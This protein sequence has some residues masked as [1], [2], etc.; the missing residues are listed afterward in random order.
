MSKPVSIAEAGRALRAGTT[1][2]VALTEAALARI[3]LK[4]P[5]LDAFVLL[6]PERALED[7]KRADAELAAGTDRGPFHGIPHALK[8]I[9]ATA[10][11]R[12]SCHS[13]LRL[14]VVPE[15]DCAVAEKFAEGGAVLLGK[16]ATHEFAIG[17][18]SFDLP[19]PPARNP[20]NRAHI[21]AGSSSG[22]GAAVA[23]GMMRMAMGSDTGGSIRGP[24]AYCGIVG[25]KPTYGRVSRRGVFPLSFTL[26]H[27]GPLS[28]N[29]EDAA[30]ALQVIAGFD[31]LDAACADMKVPDFREGMDKG[32]AGLRIGI[33]RAFFATAPAVTPDV[34]A[35]ID[36]VA[37][38]LRE[39]GAM[40]EDVTLPDMALFSA[41][42]RALMIA[43][44][45][46]IHETDLRERPRDYGTITYQRFIM[47]ACITSADLMQALRLR[48]TLTDAVDRVL[49]RYDAL[50]T[51]SA[52]M[53]A[54]RF[55]A[56][57]DP[58][59]A[60]APVQTIHFNVTGH[61]AIAVPTGLSGGMPIGVQI[62]GRPWD[63]AMVLRVGRAV[64]TLS[65]WESRVT[66]AD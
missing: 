31:P 64:E 35:E 50:L 57:L 27:C 4:N 26:D 59:P 61:P 29:V 49:D 17:G 36:R 42:G 16:L 10:G 45:F 2:S 14:D 1:T 6:T 12:T 9:Y 53:P 18:P 47:G 7:A 66:P 23:S 43:E 51:A 63:E 58:R 13:R 56:V 48:R 65:G 28:A 41:C 34:L 15:A 60:A 54:P 55:D 52:L 22:S 24:A 8:D 32:V 3:A 30:I 37:G 39:A 62:A 33:P 38:L 19:F 40:V 21:P 44:A 11:I 25:L 46:A 20:W 5:E